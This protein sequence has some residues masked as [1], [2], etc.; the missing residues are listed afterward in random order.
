MEKNKVCWKV[1][2]KCNQGC[3]YCYG[4]TNIKDLDYEDNVKVLQN[5]IDGGLTHITWTGGEAIIYPY[6][7]E[8][9]KVS[10]EKGIHNK[11][12]TNGIFLAENDNIDDYIE[13]LESITLSIDS[14]SDEIN[15]ELGKANKHFNIIKTVLDKTKNKNIKININTVVSRKNINELENLGEFL[16][17]YK[18]DT[19]KFLKFMPIREKAAENKSLFEVS[20]RE[21]L[22]KV[23]SLHKFENIRKA[24]YK[25]QKELEKSI[26]VIPN[27]DIIKTENGIDIKKGNALYEK[28]TVFNENKN[29]IKKIKTLIVHNNDEIRNSIVNSINNLEY[30]DLVGTASTNNEAYEKIIGLKPDVVFAKYNLDLIKK[31][32]ETLKNIKLELP[33]VPNIDDININRLS[34]KRDEKI[35]EE[36]IK[37]KDDV[38]QNLYKDNLNLHRELSRQTKIIEEAEKYQE[39]RDS[40]ITDNEKLHNQVENIQAEYKEKEF[41]MEWKYKSKIKSLEKENNH[42]H[43]VVDKFY[44]TVEKFI[45]W[46]CQ[47]FG[48]GESK[49]LVREFEKETN[50]YMDPEKQLKKEERAKEWDLE[51]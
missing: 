26:V 39:E 43:K 38:I 4:F 19:W 3:K 20:E 6:F 15:E 7:K 29:I 13:N 25:E 41:D 1:T 23:N 17:Q 50:M 45:D 30:I 46:I 47:K 28:V 31:T 10:K 8:L 27:G 35:L 48:I 12:V 18:I 32:K 49:E 24:Y 34:K 33:N 51:I 44:E 5:L 37:P 22:D 11:L 21:L 2:T 40:I 9:V 36:I 14:T 42:L 16:N